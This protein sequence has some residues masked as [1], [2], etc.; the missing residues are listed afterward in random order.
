M[1]NTIFSH[2]D[3][4]VKEAE[5]GL[6]FGDVFLPAAKVRQ[7]HRMLGNRVDKLGDGPPVPQ[8]EAPPADTQLASNR[9]KTQAA[10]DSVKK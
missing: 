8:P 9:A 10:R 7:L 3:L 1:A 6:L 5:D 4:V 2:E